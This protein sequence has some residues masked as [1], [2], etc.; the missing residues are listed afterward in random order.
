MRL[1]A[2]PFF[3]GLLLLALAVGLAAGGDEQVSAAPVVTNVGPRGL[4]VLHTWL[5]ERG[6]DVRVGRDGLEQ[7]PEDV[8]TVVIAAPTASPFDD[9]DVK[10]LGALLDRG[11]TVVLLV[12]RQG[13]RQVFAPLAHLRPGPTTPF[14]PVPLDGAGT[15][16]QV[17]HQLGP[18]RGVRELRVAADSAI[19]VTDEDAVPLTT[20]PVLWLK[21]LGRGQLFIAAGADLAENARLDLADNAT[22]W[23]N[24]A[25]DGPLWI[26][27]TLHAVRTRKTPTVNLWA[28]GL[29]FLFAAALFVIAR[30][31]R[32][33]PPREE[34]SAPLRSSTEYVE[35]M[36][37][38][39]QLSRLEPEL[40]EALRRQVRLTLHERLGVSL[41]LP[42]GERARELAASLTLSPADAHAL[43]VEPD[44]LKLSRLVAKLEGRLAGRKDA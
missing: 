13:A 25:A 21:P 11:A 40:V 38:L 30:G 26:D 34:P 16:V 6:A 31:S 28:S 9:A 4:K 17:E 8:R 1:G 29:Q 3:G 2:W 35:A 43:F 20:P 7:I 14:E 19:R 24:L 5:S 10:A 37:R 36:A 23:L 18:L 41:Q 39:T 27:E 32:L 12:A 22:L 42:D 44:F 33:G 15:T